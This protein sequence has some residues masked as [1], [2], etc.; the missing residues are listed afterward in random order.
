MASQLRVEDIWRGEWSVLHDQHDLDRRIHVPLNI[1]FVCCE[2]LLSALRMTDISVPARTS[3]RTTAHT[4]E[5]TICHLLDVGC[6]QSS[7]ISSNGEQP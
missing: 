6:A 1:N 3:G 7:Q 5:Y 2:D 4:E